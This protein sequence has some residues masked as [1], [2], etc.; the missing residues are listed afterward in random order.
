MNLPLPNLLG[1]FQISNV[2]T[3]IAAARNL[4][5]FKITESHIR[6]AITKVRSEGRLQSITQGKLR[7]YVSENN[8]IIIADTR[9]RLQI[10]NKD[11]DY[12]EPP[13]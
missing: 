1:D 10:Y 13:A 12:I 8:Q 9:G 11:I 2:S 7:K 4:D 6:R 3:A 5:Q